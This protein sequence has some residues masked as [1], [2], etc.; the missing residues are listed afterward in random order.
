MDEDRAAG[1]LP[2]EQALDHFGALPGETGVELEPLVGLLR[3]LDLIGLVG[4]QKIAVRQALRVPRGRQRQTP[5]QGLHFRLPSI[6]PSSNSSCT[7][8]TR[9]FTLSSSGRSA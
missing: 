8:W 6:N 2:G 4:G 1:F 9:A 7:C 3:L 5:Q